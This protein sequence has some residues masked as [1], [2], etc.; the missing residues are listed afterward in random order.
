MC[1]RDRTR[2]RVKQKEQTKHYD[3]LGRRQV[4]CVTPP[5]IKSEEGVRIIVGKTEKRK[6]RRGASKYGSPEIISHSL[7]IPHSAITRKITRLLMLDIWKVAKYE[8]R[9]I[10]STTS[11]YQRMLKKNQESQEKI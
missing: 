8:F 2:A 10:N 3:S 5:G 1:R 6:I 9:I 4:A 7:F 11:F